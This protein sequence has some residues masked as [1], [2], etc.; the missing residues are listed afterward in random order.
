MPDKAER[1]AWFIVAECAAAAV[2]TCTRKNDKECYIDS[3]FKSQF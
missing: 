1:R 2:P 3:V